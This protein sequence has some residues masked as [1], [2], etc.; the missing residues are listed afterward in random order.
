MLKAPPSAARPRDGRRRVRGPAR[1]GV[2]TRR[3]A[4]R[5][6]VTGVLA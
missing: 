5:A 4:R 2:Y 1:V 6:L 3:S